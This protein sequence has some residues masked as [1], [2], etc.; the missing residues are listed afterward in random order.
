MFTIA[1]FN[2]ISDSFPEW[3]DNIY[4]INAGKAIIISHIFYQE[5]NIKNHDLY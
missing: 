2:G 4:M 3:M 5:K 1:F